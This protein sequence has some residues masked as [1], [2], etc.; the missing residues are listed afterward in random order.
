[1]ERRQDALVQGLALGCRRRDVE[2][3]QWASGSCAALFN[4]VGVDHGGGEVV[5]TEQVMDRADV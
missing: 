3:V 5:V 1:M 2:Q 4:H